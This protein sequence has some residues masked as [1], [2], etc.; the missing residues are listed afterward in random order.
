MIVAEA[1]QD[2]SR[3]GQ[4]EFFPFFSWFKRILLYSFFFRSCD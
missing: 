1:V 3:E 2:F 4:M